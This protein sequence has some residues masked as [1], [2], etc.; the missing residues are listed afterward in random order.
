MEG[1]ESGEE[2]GGRGSGGDEKVERIVQ[3]SAGDWT[4]GE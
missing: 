2:C 1:R 4:G 3:E